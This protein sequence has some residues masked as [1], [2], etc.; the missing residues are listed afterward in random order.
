MPGSSGSASGFGDFPERESRSWAS[1]S[2]TARSCGSS[3]AGF[4]ASHGRCRTSVWRLWRSPRLRSYSCVRC[5]CP[6]R[7]KWLRPPG[8]PPFPGST[9][10]A[11]CVPCP[12][13]MVRFAFSIVTWNAFVRPAPEWPHF[14]RRIMVS[15]SQ[16]PLVTFYVMA[17]NQERFIREA[18]EGALRQTY[19]PL[20]VVLSDDCSTDG[21]FAIMQEVV[22]AYSGPHK[23]VLRW[24]DRNLGIS[25]H[26]NRILQ[27]AEGELIV[28]A[29][30][31]DVSLPGRTTRFVEAWLRHGKPAALVCGVSFID[32]SG[33][34]TRSDESFARFHPVKPETREAS[35]LRFSKEGRPMLSTCCAAFS[36]ELCEV[37]GPLPQN[38]WIE[39]TIISLRA[40][41]FDR[42]VFIPDALVNYRTHESNI[43]NRVAPHQTEQA[44]HRAENLVRTELL[45]RREALMVF[46]PDLEL[47]V[48]RNWITPST[49]EEITRLAKEQI[50]R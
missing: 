22:K 23:V 12:G 48:R 10:F 38:V 3:H 25:E 19:S 47:A 20:E 29:D 36:R 1:I 46:G 35:L 16:A 7:G 42:I 45:W 21:T 30:G 40:W 13:V 31:D 37:F 24:N 26:V 34:R 33:N 27:I 8:Q 11:R 14:F 44:R 2:I 15:S 41:L 32:E 17:Y 39:D 6:P 43:T 5:S 28:A 4:P 50:D 18:V 9:R 49:R